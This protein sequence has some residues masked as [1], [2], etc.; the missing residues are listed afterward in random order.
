MESNHIYAMI[1]FFVTLLPGLHPAS[2]SVVLKHEFEKY[3]ITNEDFESF[4][5][6]DA[7]IVPKYITAE[8]TLEHAWLST[9]LNQITGL[10]KNLVL[11]KQNTCRLEMIVEAMAIAHDKKYL[12]VEVDPR[13]GSDNILGWKAVHITHPVSFCK[14]LF[15]Y[16]IQNFAKWNR[17][18]SVQL[19]KHGEPLISQS[20][21]KM[22]L[23][24]VKFMLTIDI[25]QLFL[26]L[27]MKMRKLDLPT[28]IQE[29]WSEQ[30]NDCY[31]FCFTRFEYDFT[32]HEQ[33]WFSDWLM[34]EIE[35]TKWR[36]NVFN[37]WYKKVR[38]ILSQGSHNRR[39]NNSP[40]RDV[41]RDILGMIC[42]YY[43]DFDGL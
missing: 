13:A 17:F 39:C 10:A 26:F 28:M 29:A 36:Q 24:E 6:S 16:I 19:G 43:E 34:F 40:L 25:P 38:L 42:A 15:A 1:D 8:K 27:R 35:Q 18:P 9:A 33:R 21:Q 41:P 32:M 31:G 37:S 23:S 11:S 7:C 30:L 22:T 2:M 20:C 3:L 12:V 14:L 4:A 5:H